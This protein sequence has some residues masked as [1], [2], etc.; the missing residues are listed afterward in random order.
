MIYSSQIILLL[1]ALL[2]S[3]ASGQVFVELCKS[4]KKT[5]SQQAIFDVLSQKHDTKTCEE[6]FDAIEKA[7]K[8]ALKDRRIADLSP[9]AGMTS[10]RS[11]VVKSGNLWD[12]SALSSVPNLEALELEDTGPVDFSHLHDLSR[13]DL[14]ALTHAD[15]DYFAENMAILR[16]MDTIRHLYLSHMKVPKP[17]QNTI[18]AMTRL[19]SLS[20][21]ADT[22]NVRDIDFVKNMA[23]LDYLNVSG[24]WVTDL[25]PL[26]HTPKLT[27]LYLVGTPVHS[28]DV[29]K[30][31]CGNIRALALHQTLVRDLSPLK[32]CTNASIL[33]LSAMKLRKAPDLAANQKL[34]QLILDD[35]MIED[36]STL[37]Q[38][39]NL[40]VLK[41]KNN[42]VKDISPI[43]D[44]DKLF[45]FGI[46]GNPL[47][48]EIEKTPENCPVDGKS[49]LIRKWCSL[50]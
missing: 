1:L 38:N 5:E 32:H 28:I 43:K 23:N 4:D 18:A 49:E 8:V 36:I 20:I 31:A 41:L 39:P 26:K 50:P 24:T 48:T 22:Y 2:P 33:W 19:E 12:I 45:A 46:A 15:N 37:K 40:K 17:I 21:T 25:S 3:G 14:V 29:F 34:R 44:L 30:F 9:L 27:S 6:T 42:L 13:L 7:G 11:V 16:D 47:G 10:L 35:N